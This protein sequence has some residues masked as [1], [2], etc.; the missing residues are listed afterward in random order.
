[1]ENKIRVAAYCRV[2]TDLDSQDGSFKIQQE[3]YE[4][5]VA[6]NPNYEL[7]KIYGDQGKSGRFIKGRTAFQEMISDCEAGKIDLILSKS[8]SRFARNM[9]ECI[10]TIRYLKELG[11]ACH[12]EKE[13]FN[14]DGEYSELL[15]T[16][17]ATI[18]QEESNSIRDNK[19]MAERMRNSQGKPS[20]PASYGY[21]RAKKEFD[22][23]VVD[24]EA[25]MVKLV[26]KL[27]CLGHNYIDIMELANAYDQAHNNTKFWNR[28]AVTYVL[29]NL[30]YTGD[31]LTNK[32]YCIE[33]DNGKQQRRNQGN[34]DQFLIEEHH[35]ALV[36]HEAYEV[37]QE[38]IKK[39]LLFKSRVNFSQDDMD[40]YERARIIAN[41][42]FRNVGCVA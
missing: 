22:W 8:I 40:T 11:V 3:Y 37:V 2:S 42:E 41:T 13:G 18:A 38:L 12:F 39:H 25:E 36:S 35:E 14:T 7:V 28:N 19:M 30:C 23:L 4:R 24:E 27:A 17:F 33:T 1:M 9:L 20:V 5:I 26:F 29:T 10:K 16:I 34:V 21:R 32:T 6:E 15:L 31:L